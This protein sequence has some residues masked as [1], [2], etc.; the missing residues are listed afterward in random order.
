MARFKSILGEIRGS[1]AGTTFSR[2]GNSAYA[3][4]KAIPVNPRSPGQTLSRANLAFVSALWRTL[5]QAQQ[6]AWKSLSLTVPYTN[7]VGDSSFYS[8]FQLFMKLNQ[9]LKQ[10]G[11]A[12][13]LNAPGGAPTFP[14][15][16][17]QPAYAEQD[18]A[19]P[20]DFSLGHGYTLT[21]SG[22][23]FTLQTQATTAVSGGRNFVNPAE[24]RAVTSQT[25]IVTTNPA[26]IT[27]NW[28]AVFGV[29]T[30]SLIG[31]AIFV[32]VRMVDLASGFASPWV[33]S[34]AIVTEA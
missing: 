30:A 20:A 7:S 31:S 25:P 6:D 3:R 18:G 16:A 9:T 17:Y 34:K 8:G 22:T 14:A 29:P 5:T 28:E 1:I 27:T 23:G 15:L 11:Q 12:P 33:E 26:I 19:T 10:A 13:I 4:N 32:R 21:G 2:N 24:Y